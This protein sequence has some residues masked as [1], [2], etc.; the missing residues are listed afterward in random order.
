MI[1]DNRVWCGLNVTILAG[2]T[3]G[4]DVVIGA[5]SV[6]INDVPSNSVVAGIPAK[7]IKELNRDEIKIVSFFE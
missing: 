2:V 7:L 3:I 6:V 1:I 5:G 4:N